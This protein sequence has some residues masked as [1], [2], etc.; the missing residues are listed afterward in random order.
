M[1]ANHAEA[2]PPA[3]PP[4]PAKAK[5]NPLTD[6]ID[7]EKEYVDRLAGVI[8]VRSSYTL[9][10]QCC[11]RSG[12]LTT[13]AFTRSRNS[14]NRKSQ[15]HGPAPTSRRQSLTPCLEPSKPCI[16]QIEDLSRCEYMPLPGQGPEIADLA[17][18]T[19]PSTPFTLLSRN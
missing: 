10:V 4:K 6:L 2:A 12:G 13:T 19:S 5:G 15:R 16:V 18:S 11:R 8:R 1:E 14:S 7:S 9:A 3:A 17:A